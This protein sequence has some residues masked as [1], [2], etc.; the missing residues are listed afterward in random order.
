MGLKVAFQM[1][2]IASLHILG[3]S[4]FAI[5]L[6]AQARGHELFYYLPS[7]LSFYEGDVLASGHP[8]S[9][10]DVEGD[11]FILRDKQRVNLKEFDVVHLRQDPP[12]DMSYITTTHLLEMI[13]PETL[14]VNNPMQVRNAPEKLYLL[15]YLQLTAPTLITRSSEEVMRFRDEWKDIIVKPLYGNGGEGVFRIAPTDTNLS[16]LIELFTNMSREPFIVQQYL[17]AVREG[18]KRII[19]V[20]GEPFGAIN[21]VPAENETRSNMHIGGRPE[22]IE[23]DDRDQEICAAIGPELKRRG[24]IFVGIDVIGGVLT[25]INVTSPTGIRE[26]K[27]FGGADIAALIWDAIEEKVS[28]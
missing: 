20:D 13:Q 3:D 9:V 17:P 11:H 15:N 21:R 25:E 18:D 14:V 8:V 1:D 22:P 4:T 26:V 10:Q 27:K 28:D 7:N 19:L 16:S 6:E 24:L 2:D 5:M 12:F 23:L